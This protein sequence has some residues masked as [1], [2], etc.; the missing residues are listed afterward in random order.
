[1]SNWL[2][3]EAQRVTENGV[4]SDWGLV[5]SGALQS[6]ILGSVLFNIFIN[7]LD[8][9]LEEIIFTEYVKFSI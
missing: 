7:E 6:A 5:T 9:G 4:T 1:M 8:A 3:D 2:T